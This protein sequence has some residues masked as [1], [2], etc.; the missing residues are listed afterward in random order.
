MKR[1]FKTITATGPSNPRRRFAVLAV[2]GALVPAAA[3]AAQSEAPGTPAQALARS[4]T[5]LNVVETLLE[6][7]NNEAVQAYY[8][9]RLAKG[10]ADAANRVRCLQEL[11]AGNDAGAQQA[12]EI[13]NAKDSWAQSRAN[14][15]SGLVSLQSGFVESR[16]DHF[17][18]RVPAE[19][20][21]LGD[22][23]LPALENAHAKFA[24]VLGAFSSGTAV[25]E[26]YPTVE[27]FSFAST[28]SPEAIARTGTVAVFKFGRLMILSPRAT[29]RGYRW[30][31]ALVHQ[32]ARAAVR[33]LTGSRCPV[34]LEEGTARYLT[35]VWRRTD[36]FVL[37]P[38]DEGL[39]A[40]AASTA[41]A[42]GSVP[43]VPF[44]KMEPAF[45]YLPD[46]A[47]VALAE[48]E[49]SD[50]VAY[51]VDEHG[52]DG[53]RSLLTAL[54][55]RPREEAFAAAVGS[56]EEELEAGWRESLAEETLN[57]PAGALSSAVQLR[58]LEDAVWA[59]AAAEPFLRAGDRLRQQNQWAAAAAQYRKGLEAAPDNGLLMTRLARTLLASGTPEAAEPLL[60]RAAEKNPAFAE[61]FVLM[62]DTFFDDGRYE[63][64]Q[65]VLQSA[66]EINP[67]DPKVHE[68]LG[69]IAVD[70]GNFAEARRSL[71]LA[72]R[73]DPEN[74][75]VAQALKRMPKRR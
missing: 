62:G 60:R 20:A 37:P 49:A 32:Y 44:D 55:D 61:P 71:Q 15:L 50:A 23:A 69:L 40:A 66:L 5:P 13:L 42:P 34:W 56:T 52:L 51:V 64:A 22:Y 24:D 75:A 59:G 54:K 6:S 45:V 33:R 7:G 1:S 38:Y 46:P 18:V 17:V 48:S 70:V 68:I 10:Q 4:A 11:Y 12:L 47:T 65:A 67:F 73:F 29:A 30:L 27:S 25:V 8:E 72:L 19:D 28:L 57:A 63:E 2:L 26:I 41:P 21:F 53:L 39:L 35:I 3:F 9:E 36:E 14:Y 74:D 58:P 31:D 43:W 16:S